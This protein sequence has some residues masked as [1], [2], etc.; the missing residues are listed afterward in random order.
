M[1]VKAVKTGWED[2]ASVTDGSM[3]SEWLEGHEL[4]EKYTTE[5]FVGL[6]GYEMTWSNGLGHMNTFNTPG[7]QSRTQGEY[8]N[9]GTALQNYY[10]T[11]QKTPDSIS[12]FNHPGTTFGDFSDF[13]HYSEANDALITMIEVGNGEG[14]IGSSGYFPSYE[15]YTR[16]L[17][18]GW[19]VAPTNNQD[20]HKGKWGDAN[21]A[22]SVVLADSLTEENIYDAMRNCRVYATEDN[23]LNIYYTL[24]SYVMGTVLNKD[25]VG[26]QIELKVDL[27]DATDSKIGKVE[28]IVN[29]GLSIA[30]QD[31]NTNDEVI[32]FKVPSSYSYYYVKVT[33]ADGD[34][35][36][37]APVWVGEVEAA[38][39]NGIS[40]G[41]SLPIKGEALD[42]TLDLYNN[43]ATDMAVQSIE[44]VVNDKVVESVDLA[45]TGLDKIV[46][47]S[48]GTYT[49]SYTYNDVGSMKM[50]VV[51]KAKLAGAD[52][53][54]L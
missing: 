18:K 30:S 17:D 40:T 53:F 21:T 44:F 54:C 26:E 32:T 8:T 19:H 11:L 12:Q 24:D 2:S 52:I 7:F 42:V 39:I 10:E 33:Q 6:F 46:S 5:D 14:A 27:Q 28:I 41:E 29:G 45:S 4:A 48:T 36:V 16:A 34:I 38:G 9:F 43:E 22:R 35:A 20:N 31:V 37:T 1:A 25:M 47:G 3:S 51:V 50:D 23:D 15:Y 13:A 49:F